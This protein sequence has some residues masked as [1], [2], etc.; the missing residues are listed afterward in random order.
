MEN[1]Q[2][3]KYK[4]ILQKVN[5]L[6]DFNKMRLWQV[7]QIYNQEQLEKDKVRELFTVN[8]GN[9]TEEIIKIKENIFITNVKNSKTTGIF[10]DFWSIVINGKNLS[11][12]Y[13]DQESALIGLVCYL[14]LGNILPVGWIM[15]MLKE[16]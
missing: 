12:V 5:N 2:N 6:N 16:D 7:N 9:Y 3:E 11:E 13:P 10:S 15:R 8:Q 1:N 4:E 14:K